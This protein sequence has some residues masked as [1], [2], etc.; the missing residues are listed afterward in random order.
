[1]ACVPCNIGIDDASWSLA[2]PSAGWAP[3]INPSVHDSK[4]F[5]HDVFD[6]HLG[7]RQPLPMRWPPRIARISAG[8]T[9]RITATGD[10]S[11]DHH[12][13]TPFGPTQSTPRSTWRLPYCGAAMCCCHVATTRGEVSCCSRKLVSKNIFE[14]TSEAR[15]KMASQQGEETAAARCCCAAVEAPNKSDEQ[16]WRHR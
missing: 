9:Y 5:W 12:P 16:P 2:V 10:N 14:N 7:A 6:L 4:G 8:V 3:D 11:E 1:M 13:W 15:A